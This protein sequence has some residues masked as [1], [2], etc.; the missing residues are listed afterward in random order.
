MSYTKIL[1]RLIHKI[2]MKVLMVGLD[3]SRRT[4]T[5]RKL[6]LDVENVEDNGVHCMRV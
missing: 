4:T 2:E 6:K 5:W 3:A 1:K